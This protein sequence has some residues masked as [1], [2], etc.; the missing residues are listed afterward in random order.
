MDKN[1]A[2]QELG[3]LSAKKRDTSPEAMREL[4][5]RRWRKKEMMFKIFKKSHPWIE[6]DDLPEAFR[7][8]QEY[9]ERKEKHQTKPTK[10]RHSDIIKNRK[11]RTHTD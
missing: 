2:A 8:W 3:K 6:V 1:K 9:H 5:R 7:K 11:K 10:G 4:V